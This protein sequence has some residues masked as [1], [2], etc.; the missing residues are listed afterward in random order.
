MSTKN[1]L[2]PNA[3]TGVITGSWVS[4]RRT[5][6]LVSSLALGWLWVALPGHVQAQGCVQS[7][8]AGGP[9]M[10]MHDE[11]MSPKPGQWQVSVGYRWLHSDREFSGID[12]I[13]G[14]Q[15]GGGEENKSR[16]TLHDEMINDSHFID[17][18][19]TYVITKRFSASLTLPLVTSDRSVPVI[20]HTTGTILERYSTHAEGLSDVSLRGY[21]WIFDPHGH[22]DGNLQLGVGLKFPTGDSRVKD[23]TEIYNPGRGIIIAR[24]LYVDQSIQP[25]DGGLG[26][27]LQ[28]Q[29]FQKIVKNTFA[30]LDASYLINPQEKDT[31]TQYSIP[32]AYLLRAGLSYAVWPSKGLSLSL[33]ARM[34]GVP[35]TDWFG[36]ST[37]FR[38]PG[39]AISIEPGVTW[40]Y[41]QLSISVTAP[42]ALERNREKSVAEI[43]SGQHGDA[44]FADFVITSSVS[45]RF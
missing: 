20:D 41:K 30:Y 24:K 38:R 40:M 6:K 8:G 39:Y 15:V 16:S 5:L 29:G 44:A 43:A 21:A 18:T 3:I 17:L 45:L 13:T 12:E 11:D 22:P 28:A 32:D 35:V 31:A 4:M 9:C 33:G 27:I 25:G 34:E 10:L 19:A 37:G 23:I 7:R 42:V 1:N 14:R 26:V 36:E 2:A